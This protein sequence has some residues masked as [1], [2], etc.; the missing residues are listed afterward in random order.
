MRVK[1]K[2]SQLLLQGLAVFAVPAVARAASS[3]FGFV[4]IHGKWGS[5]EDRMPEVA[6][7]LRAAGYRVE[8]PEKSLDLVTGYHGLIF[9][10]SEHQRVHRITLYADE[11]PLTFP[12]QDISLTLDYDYTRIGEGDF[13]LPLRF[14]LRSREGIQLIRNYVEYDNYRKF[15]VVSVITFGSQNTSKK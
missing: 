3:D 13:L 14:E 2:R 1:M 8:V 10:D 6:S 12:I 5:P 4:L 15:D 11:I 9:I 7:A